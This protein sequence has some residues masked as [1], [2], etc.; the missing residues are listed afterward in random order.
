M[1][2]KQNKVEISKKICSKKTSKNRKNI[3]KTPKS[4]KK[5]HNSLPII[6]KLREKILIF[7]SNGI[8]KDMFDRSMNRININNVYINKI[9]ISDKGLYVKKVLFN[10]SLDTKV[11]MILDH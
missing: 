1:N 11:I 5:N 2:K 8:N 7:G 3:K 4:Q 6:Q 10:T 9:V